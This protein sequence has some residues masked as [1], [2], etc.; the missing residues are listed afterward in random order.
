M[1]VSNFN[2]EAAP[3]AEIT[4]TS[5]G[6][7]S[8][9]TITTQPTLHKMLRK[10]RYLNNENKQ[11]KAGALFEVFVVGNLKN[12]SYSEI[13]SIELSFFEIIF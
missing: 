4:K 9:C 7:I 11:P 5:S 13:A 6:S 2:A 12:D 8:V 3:T 10:V 1:A